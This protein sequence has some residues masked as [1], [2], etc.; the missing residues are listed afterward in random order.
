MKLKKLYN[1]GG[2]MHLVEP[3]SQAD[4][5]RLDTGWTETAPKAKPTPK[6][7]AKTDKAE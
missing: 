2:E 7:T 4:I 1:K 6:P 3:G 5:E